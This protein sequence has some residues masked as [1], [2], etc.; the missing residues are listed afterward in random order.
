[1]ASDAKHL[2]QVRE[3]SVSSAARTFAFA[4]SLPTQAKLSLCLINEM[5]SRVQGAPLSLL[6]KVADR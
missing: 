2:L 6:I 5:L 3:A 1:M 4:L